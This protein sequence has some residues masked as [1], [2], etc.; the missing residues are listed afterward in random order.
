[1]ALSGA[2]F[3]ENAEPLIFMEDKE[4]K[5]QERYEEK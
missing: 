2:P 1:M 3:F 5:D 4:T